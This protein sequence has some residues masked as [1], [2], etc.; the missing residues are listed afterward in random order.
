MQNGAGKYEVLIDVA[1]R[2]FDVDTGELSNLP[3]AF[4][5]A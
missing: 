4:S 2:V 5:A 1:S 3:C